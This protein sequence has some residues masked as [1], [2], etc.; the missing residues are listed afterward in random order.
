MSALFLS[1]GH[2]CVRME[3]V[4]FAGL[5][6]WMGRLGRQGQTHIWAGLTETPARTYVRGYIARVYLLL[7]LNEQLC[8]CVVPLLSSSCCG[9]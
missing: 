1:T 3:E 2:V 7:L 5:P 8:C 6:T 9:L 4:D